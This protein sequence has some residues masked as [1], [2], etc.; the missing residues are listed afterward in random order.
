[1]PEPKTRHCSNS[2]RK[3]LNESSV[4]RH[5][6]QSQ[7]ASQRSHSLGCPSLYG[8]SKTTQS[9]TKNV[10]RTRGRRHMLHLVALLCD[11]WC[12]STL[13]PHF[14][15]EGL[16]HSMY[17]SMPAAF[18]CSASGISSLFSRFAFSTCAKV[19]ETSICQ[20][21]RSISSCRR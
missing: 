2:R 19:L 8:T 6:P 13:R 15:I 21:F 9:H 18:G 12:H 3:T 4:L 7:G 11:R 14:V 17:N 10:S 20:V 16:K 1:M 5:K